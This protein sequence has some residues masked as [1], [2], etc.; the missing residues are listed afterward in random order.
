MLRVHH[1]LILIFGFFGLLACLSACDFLAPPAIQL[2]WNVT[3][4]SAAAAQPA[5]NAKP[6]RVARH[7]ALTMVFMRPPGVIW[8]SCP[9]IFRLR[10]R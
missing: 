8:A 2:S 4:V 7:A 6:A 1:L 10:G 9:L 3:G 5:A